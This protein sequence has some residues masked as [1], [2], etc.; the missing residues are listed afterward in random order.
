[1]P[2]K[3]GQSGNPKGK[4]KGAKS[5]VTRKRETEI[6]AAGITP[7][8]YMLEVLRDITQPTERRDEMAKAAAPYIHPKLASIEAN[9]HQESNVHIMSDKPMTEDEWTEQ[10]GVDLGSTTGTAESLN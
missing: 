10:Y 1:M 4:P 6:L 9:V 3:P 2:F 5:H 7:L 8:D